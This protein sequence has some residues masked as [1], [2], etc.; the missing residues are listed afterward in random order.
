M[1][2]VTSIVLAERL[3]PCVCDACVLVPDDTFVDHKCHGLL[4]CLTKTLAA[5]QVLF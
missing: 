4:E 5:Q 2:G 1:Q 3:R